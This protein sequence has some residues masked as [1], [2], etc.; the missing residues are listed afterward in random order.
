MRNQELPQPGDSRPGY[1]TI[2]TY[3]V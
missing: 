1:A 3:T 2:S